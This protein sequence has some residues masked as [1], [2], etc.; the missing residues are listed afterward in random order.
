MEKLET[1]IFK[2]LEIYGLHKFSHTV[3]DIC[4][5]WYTCFFS[6]N[7]LRLGKNVVNI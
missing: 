6:A 2:N 3:V 1:A 4:I 7:W 5:F